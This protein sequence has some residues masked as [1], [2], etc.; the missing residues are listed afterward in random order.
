MVK[1]SNKK[2]GY[3]V[4]FFAHRGIGKVIITTNNMENTKK[5]LMKDSDTSHIVCD[6]NQD[7]AIQKYNNLKKASK[8]SKVSKVSNKINRHKAS[9][10]YNHANRHK[11]SKKSNKINRHKAPKASNK[12]KLWFSSLWK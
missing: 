7:I 11:S 3:C 5:K 10:K 9:K 4:Y 1:K 12:L 6:A 2:S 8:V